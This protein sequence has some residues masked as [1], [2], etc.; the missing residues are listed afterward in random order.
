V[1]YTNAVK[2]PETLLADFFAGMR[3]IAKPPSTDDVAESDSDADEEQKAAEDLAREDREKEIDA[4]YLKQLCNVYAG[5]RSLRAM[6]SLDSGVP[7]PLFLG[8][9]PP[10]AV[11]DGKAFSIILVTFII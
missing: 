3:A 1:I 4:A 7:S 8:T 11:D 5:A 2:T 10:L 9:N 6:A